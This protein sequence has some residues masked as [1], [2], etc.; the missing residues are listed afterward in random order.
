MGMA[1]HP[2]GEAIR[3][4]TS[5]R[6]Y[7]DH[8][9]LTRPFSIRPVTM[10]VELGLASKHWSKTVATVTYESEVCIERIRCTEEIKILCRIVRRRRRL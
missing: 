7:D 1:D 8:P 6:H 4:T 5:H 3:S 10:L 2:L 9:R